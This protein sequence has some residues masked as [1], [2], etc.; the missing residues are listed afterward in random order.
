MATEIQAVRRQRRSVSTAVSPIA[1]RLRFLSESARI[2]R[3]DVRSDESREAAIPRLH[4]PTDRHEF[5]RIRLDRK[6][7]R[8]CGNW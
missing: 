7:S 4:R 3:N 5:S 2:E 1:A 6:C 8:G